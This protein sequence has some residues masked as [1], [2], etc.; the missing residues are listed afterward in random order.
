MIGPLA[1]N[2]F[3]DASATFFEAIGRAL[4]IGLASPIAIDAPFAAMH[5]SDVI[6]LGRS[7]GVPFEL[8][9]SCM[10]TGSVTRWR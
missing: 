7:L 1:G 10:D 3:P 5:K 2:P 4:S 6:A 9:L 8:T